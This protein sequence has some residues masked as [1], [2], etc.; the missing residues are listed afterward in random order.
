MPCDS[1]PLQIGVDEDLS[2]NSGVVSGHAEVF[3][4]GGRKAA[5]CVGRET[6]AGVGRHLPDCA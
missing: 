5:Q 6:L 4:R 2:G 1:N 3:Q